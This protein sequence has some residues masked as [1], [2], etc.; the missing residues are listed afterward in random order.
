[1]ATELKKFD[2][3]SLGVRTLD[4]QKLDDQENLD[5]FDHDFA[6][7]KEIL[8]VEAIAYRKL[9]SDLRCVVE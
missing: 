6:I 5:G 2:T 8:R 9:V 4:Q 1:M 7:N 3:K